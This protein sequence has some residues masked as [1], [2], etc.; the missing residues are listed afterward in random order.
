MVT[1][2]IEHPIRDFG[3]W[4]AA[5]DRDPADRRRSGVQRYV[6]RRP[7]DDPNYVGI[8]LDFASLAEAEAFLV[9]MRK[10]WASPQALQAL[11]GAP[12]A[13]IW[14]T[15]ASQAVPA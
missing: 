5:F 6:I 14:N 10:V 4:K 2:Q 15:E 3:A 13:R 11:A 8:D 1:V 7:V 12:Q 9:T